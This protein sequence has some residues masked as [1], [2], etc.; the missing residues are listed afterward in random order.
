M[1][2]SNQADWDSQ[3]LRKEEMIRWKRGSTRDSGADGQ[4][5]R[6]RT[7]RN[8]SGKER[9]ERKSATKRVGQKPREVVGPSGLMVRTISQT[10]KPTN[11]NPYGDIKVVRLTR[12]G[13]QRWSLMRRYPDRY[14]SE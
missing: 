2:S 9:E 5:G 4:R 8:R 7:D 1:D 13:Y 12:P 10:R 11:P 3:D 14:D 6:D